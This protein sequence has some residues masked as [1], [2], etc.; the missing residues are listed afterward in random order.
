MK[1]VF[2]C[3][4]LEP[5]RDGVGDYSRR[6]ASELIR[7]QHEVAIVALNDRRI[8]AVY[9]GSQASNEIK[10]PVLRLP[11]AMDE[12]KRFDYAGDFIKQ[13]GPDWVSLQYVPFS[14]EKRGLPFSFSNHLKRIDGN[15]RWHIMFHELWVGLYGYSNFKL[16]ML[17]LLQKLIIKQ[18][19]SAI[20]P[21]SVTTS[22]G[23]YKKSLGW[24]DVNLIPLFSN[25]PIVTPHPV[26]SD[27]S[28]NITAI[29]FGTFTS[30]LEDYKR[31]IDFL[32]AIGEKTG[33]TVC[34]QVIGDGGAYKEKAL[35]ISRQLLGK[36]NVVDCGFQSEE[37]VSGYML[38][39]DV[40]ISRADYALFG[41]SGSSMAMLEHGLPVLLRGDRPEDDMI[42]QDFPFKEQLLYIDDAPKDLKKNEPV[43]FLNQVS[44]I[45]LD[46]LQEKDKEQ[47]PNTLILVTRP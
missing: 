27:R 38:K 20:K 44:D 25:I 1:I 32:S 3:G 22:I 37:S 8:T 23:I 40:G 46:S 11:A 16:K 4:S 21:E 10:I 17:G 14:F 28:G 2:L 47:D 24:K 42:G 9:Q 36:E 30:S 31:Q 13:F 18:M 35:E 34:L 15:F 29:H 45:F 6:L 41:K 12:R 43:Y 7:K 5:G 39:A 33:K 26:Q 19:L